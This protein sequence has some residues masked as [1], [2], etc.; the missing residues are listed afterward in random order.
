M[1]RRLSASRR[2]ERR[3]PQG[4][5]RQLTDSALR[6]GCGYA[7]LSHWQSGSSRAAKVFSH[8]VSAS[9][10]SVSRKDSTRRSLRRS[11]CSVLKLE[12]H[13]GHGESCFGCGQGPRCRPCAWPSNQSLDTTPHLFTHSRP[14]GRLERNGIRPRPEMGL[15]LQCSLPGKCCPWQKPHNPTPP[16]S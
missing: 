6:V 3:S 4:R 9:V 11:V 14:A 12:R 7:A 13:G 2:G 1:P 15:A 10:S 5:I 8:L 16:R